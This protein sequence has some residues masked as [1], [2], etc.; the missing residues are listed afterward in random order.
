MA[1][2]KL[3]YVYVGNIW[4]DEANGTDC[5]NCKKPLIRRTGYNII[6][7][8]LDKGGKC[9]HCGTKIAHL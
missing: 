2:K 5:G 1:Q 8:G 7:S 9:K 4:D 6:N 3:K